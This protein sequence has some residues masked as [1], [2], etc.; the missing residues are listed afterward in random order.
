MGYQVNPSNCSFSSGFSFR[1]KGTNPLT[2]K[3]RKPSVKYKKVKKKNQTL[4]ITKVIKFTNKGQGAKTYARISGSKKIKINK[5]TGKV[6][7]KKGT[8]KGTYVI[9]IKVAASG[10]A[11]HLPASKVVAAKVVVK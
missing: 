9:K 7:V 2:V 11:N 1:K 5:K 3:A 6:T 8:K 4:G 10:D